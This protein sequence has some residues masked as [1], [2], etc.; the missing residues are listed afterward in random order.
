MDRDHA[1]VLRSSVSGAGLGIAVVT[2]II[3]GVE[4]FLRA[5]DGA[6]VAA[7][8]TVGAVPL[9]SDQQEA[10]P[11]KVH[12]ARGIAGGVRLAGQSAVVPNLCSRNRRGFGKVVG[13][14]QPFAVIRAGA[15]DLLKAKRRALHHIGAVSDRARNKKSQ[16]QFALEV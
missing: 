5:N 6:K 13:D 8:H 1:D 14:H 10:E 11:R 4:V 16:G 3:H 2:I 7:F 12:V 9:F 15:G